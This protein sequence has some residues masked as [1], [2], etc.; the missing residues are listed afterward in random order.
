MKIKLFLYCIL[1]T[2]APSAFSQQTQTENRPQA[3]LLS[4]GRQAAETSQPRAY[5]SSR[6]ERNIAGNSKENRPQA[7]RVSGGETIAALSRPRVVRTVENNQV[8]KTKTNSSLE[9]Q[10]FD[11]INQKRAM[12]SLPALEWSDDVAKIARLHSQ[13][14][15]NYK[16]FSHTG[17]DGLLVNDRA[18]DLGIRRWQAIGEN[19][20]Y[21]RGYENPVEF[22]VELWMKS[23][24]HRENLLN[25]RWKE[26]AVGVAVTED[27]TYYFTEVFLT[28][29]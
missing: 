5:L 3:Y 12:L 19:I 7:Y 26:S 14:M 20:A 23:P 18:D 4:S 16:F 29:K 8:G 17:M 13:N 25:S 6:G 9:R 10:A 22:A 28:R 11:L 24:G 2:L 21:N 1:L 15:A 27:G